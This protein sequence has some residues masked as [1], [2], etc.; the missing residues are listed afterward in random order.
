[1]AEKYNPIDEECL[2]MA[3]EPLGVDASRMAEG[4]VDEIPSDILDKAIEI[5]L[6][7]QQ[8]GTLIPAD[9]AFDMIYRELG[10]KS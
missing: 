3:C 5:A 1:M 10:W 7:E 2:D 4:E 8:R 9:E 6:I